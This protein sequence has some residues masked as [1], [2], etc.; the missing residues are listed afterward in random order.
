MGLVFKSPNNV[1]KIILKKN[2]FLV[3]IYVSYNIPKAELQIRF[4]LVP[5]KA[6]VLYLL[7]WKDPTV[8]HIICGIYV[9]QD[10]LQDVQHGRALS[11]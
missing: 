4:Q 6:S 9:I 10:P 2:T 5:I 8:I 1:T 7:I 3:G 11:G